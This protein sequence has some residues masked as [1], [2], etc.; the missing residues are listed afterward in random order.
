[1]KRKLIALCLSI[2]LSLCTLPFA[3]FAENSVQGAG[4]VVTINYTVG[5]AN[6]PVVVVIL[7]QIL[8][9]E[10]DV[11]ATKMEA[12]KTDLTAL[13]TLPVAFAKIVKTN[14]SGVLDHTC[15]VNSSLPTGLAYVYISYLGAENW[16]QAGTFEHKSYG[17][18]DRLLGWFNDG[19][20]A[21]ESAILWDEEGREDD[22]ETLEDEA[23]SAVYILRDS[24]ARVDD[25]DELEENKGTFCEIL[26][27]KKPEGGFET[28]ADLVK[29]FNESI[30]WMELRLSGNTLTVLNTYDGTASG[31]YWDLPL[32]ETDDF[33]NLSSAEQTR[34]LT[35]IK[36]GGYTDKTTLASDFADDL[37]LS[38]FRDARSRED[39]EALISADEEN[40][41]KDYFADIRT[42]LSEAGMDAE[43]KAFER[44]EVMNDVL[45]SN[46]SCE[47]LTDA[48][49]L[50]TNALPSE[51]DPEDPNEDDY[52]NEGSVSVSN[53]GGG[54]I[55]VPKPTKEE[56]PKEPEKTVGFN[57]VAKDHWA[58]SY[59]KR[60]YDD[61]VINGTGN[62][63]FS[64]ASPV[65]RQ[66]F[67][68]ILV[69]ALGIEEASAGSTFTDIGSGSYYEP[70]IMAAVEKGLIFGKNENYFGGIENI[71]REDAAVIMSRALALYGKEG[72]GESLT[73]GD[74]DAV[75]EYA[76]EAVAAVS[77]SGIFSGDE[78]G[79]FNPKAELSRA[80]ACAILCRLADLAKGGAN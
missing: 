28:I 2:V 4:G 56:E 21:Y 5:K 73:F 7:P 15:T 18:I 29:L 27:G 54:G 14:E 80:E 31:K 76:K 58:A 46:V 9:S 38:V 55:G 65:R 40:A 23:I 71:S 19:E 63:D 22:L 48:R 50:F 67:V 64:P 79:N 3:A 6:T 16:V 75:A 62:G 39:L 60:L 32:A 59:I 34:M 26:S 66:D 24:A 77:A 61:E 11:T 57:D 52:Q 78:Q 37:A 68:K 1:M 43:E 72:A 49:A 42:I 69:G 36:T 70:F 20:T 17:D 53:R 12:L 30:A 10:E 25:Y 45:L 44:S 74:G 35:N 47:S 13:E 8:E 33:S 51:E 41:Y